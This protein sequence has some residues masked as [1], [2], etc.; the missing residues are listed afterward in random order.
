M[1]EIEIVKTLMKS[2]GYSGKL[3]AEKLGYN[4]PSAVTNRLQGKTVTVEMLIKLLDAMDC[5]LIIKDKAG[6]KKS[7]PVENEN[8]NEV[9]S[10]NTSKKRGEE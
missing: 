8:R 1:N 10:Y 4:T 7:F 2:K 3:L 5:E 6:E 9:K